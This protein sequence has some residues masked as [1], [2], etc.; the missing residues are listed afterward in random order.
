MIVLCVVKFYGSDALWVRFRQWSGL[1]YE[2]KTD[3]VGNG[4]E[5]SGI[6]I[7]DVRM[8]KTSLVPINKHVSEVNKK[9]MYLQYY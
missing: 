2:M 4:T 1:W 8:H 3:T 5:Q 7:Y 9:R 6:D